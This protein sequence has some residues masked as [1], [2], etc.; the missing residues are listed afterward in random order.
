M[1]REERCCVSVLFTHISEELDVPS[2]TS[3]AWK[4]LASACAETGR[5]TQ[6][7]G[8]GSPGKQ[9]GSAFNTEQLMGRFSLFHKKKL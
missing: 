6:D 8:E 9:G 4:L 3:R 7:W 1:G 5:N 2:V